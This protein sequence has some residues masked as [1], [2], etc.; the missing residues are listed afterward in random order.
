MRIS[1]L[2][3]LLL[4]CSQVHAAIYSMNLPLQ[5]QERKIGEVA[6]VLENFSLHS[7]EGDSLA[8]P[9]ANLINPELKRFLETSEGEL[10]MATLEE[11][12]IL[13]AFNT[14]DLVVTMELQPKAWR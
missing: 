6:F 4:F 13:L 11:R 8:L 14:K 10:S 7:V 1:A 2:L 12:G 3:F 9:I 5:W